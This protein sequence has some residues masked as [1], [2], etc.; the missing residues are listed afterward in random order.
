MNREIHPLT[1]IKNRQKEKRRLIILL[2]LTLINISIFSYI[3]K[4]NLKNLLF[5]KEQISKTNEKNTQITNN[6]K[7]ENKESE[8]SQIQNNVN[9]PDIEIQINKNLFSQILKNEDIPG[10]ISLKKEQT[11]PKSKKIKKDFAYY[12]KLAK[13]AEKTGDIK[14]SLAFYHKAYKFNPDED[15]LY[16][17]ALL[18]YKLKAY[19][20]SIKYLK[21]LLKKNPNYINAYILLAKS[22][23][24]L[25]NTKKAILI[26]EETY[27]NFPN[28][29]KLMKELAYFYE[30]TKNPYAALEIYENLAKKGNLKDIIKTAKIY[31]IL[32]NKE[33]ALFYYKKALEKDDGTYKLWLEDKISKLSH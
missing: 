29:K 23:D 28:N 18:N 4:D 33:K 10:E 22:Y 13:K 30:K 17:I 8:K 31:E 2:I 19:K 20:G 14:S 16:K 11:K 32:G 12:Y 21:H 25:G 26:L 5:P 9:F 24:K 1:H 7:A 3:Y 6:S 15:I 27:Y